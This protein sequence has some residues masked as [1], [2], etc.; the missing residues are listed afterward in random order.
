LIFYKA[1]IYLNTLNITS[2]TLYFNNIWNLIQSY[3]ALAIYFFNFIQ[4]SWGMSINIE[5]L[6]TN[7]AILTKPQISNNLC[8]LELST[9]D[10]NV[11]IKLTLHKNN[12]NNNLCKLQKS[13]LSS[14]LAGL[15]ESDGSIIVPSGNVKNYKPYIEIVFHMDDLPFAEI[16]QLNIGGII[17]HKGENYCILTVK[18]IKEVIKIIHLINGNMRAYANQK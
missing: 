9:R 12:T 11:N 1:L 4:E 10:A 18:R 16:I 7:L 17:R 8:A 14:Y 3:A 2:I 5:I 13:N 6:L 15:I